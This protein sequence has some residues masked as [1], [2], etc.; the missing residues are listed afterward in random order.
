VWFVRPGLGRDVKYFP[1]QSESMS[2]AARF[3]ILAIPCS[4]LAVA[5]LYSAAVAPWGNWVDPE[6]AYAMN[7]LIG[8]AGYPS[9]KFDHPGTTTTLLVEIVVRLW[10]LIARPADII[11]FGFRNYD[12]I[13]YAA[14]AC[15][16]AVMAGVLL[17]GGFIVGNA[18]RSLVAAILFQVAPFIHPD[19]LHFLMVL[20]PD[21]LMASS[22]VLAM[23]LVVSG[24]LDP[25]PPSVRLGVVAGLI[26][27]FGFSSKY[28]FLPMAGL[29]VNLLRN[30]QAFIAAGVTGGIAFLAFN[31]ILNPGTIT[32]GF[33]WMF[34]IATHKGIYGHGE[35][36]FI[37]QEVFWSNMGVIIAAAPHVCGLY[38]VAAL[39]SLVQMARARSHSDPV[40]RAL[41]AAFVVFVAQL[42]ATSKHFALHYM[43]TS[44]VLAGGVLVLTI[45]QIRRLAPGV[46][47][48]V[49]AAV[50]AGCCAMMVAATVAEV[51]RD[52]T[53]WAAQDRVGERLSRAVV[54]AGPACAN[55]SGMFVRAPEIHISHGWDMTMAMWGDQEMKDRLSDSYARA[56]PFSLLDHNIY[57]GIVARN[58]RPYT[59][60]K[61]A[62]EYPCIVV[63]TARELG[64]TNS[65]GLLE[66]NPEHCAIEWVQIYTLGIACEKIRTAYLELP[67]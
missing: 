56:F 59:Y 34:S 39:A 19:T 58:F 48:A 38:V 33:G 55:V 12:T 37:D 23:A 17:V 5:L 63:R 3:A 28:L 42:I 31:L 62:R 18:T 61:L 20:A 44:W 8:A 47:S 50:A 43:M 13:I 40:S 21:S 22:A 57:T 9:M 16:A 25:K 30:R 64:A 27:A 52:A 53:G 66:M 41:L 36:G 15:E 6:S 14:R 2:S 10:A 46:P 7:G 35:P 60:E 67:Q 65:S 29:G 24:A 26:F 45:V 4:Y 11:A 1:D 32:R 49:L 51:S 54:E